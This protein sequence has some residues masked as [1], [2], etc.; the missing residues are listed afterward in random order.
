MA[1][2]D[3]NVNGQPVYSLADELSTRGRP[4]VLLTGYGALDLPERFR[5]WPRVAKPYDIALLTKVLARIRGGGRRVADGT[6]I[7]ID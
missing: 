7:T 3:I 1:I 5:L 2:L 4:M 6:A